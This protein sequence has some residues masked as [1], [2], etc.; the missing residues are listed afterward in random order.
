MEIKVKKLNERAILPTYGSEDAACADLYAIIDTPTKSVEI[1][2]H[3]TYF[4]STG[5]SMEIPKGYVG[6]IYPRS[7]LSCKRGLSLANCVGVIDSDYR[8]EI[9]VALVN[10][11]NEICKIEDAERCSQIAFQPSMKWDF[12]QVDELS[13]TE[14]GEGGFGSTG[15]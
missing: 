10:H 3:E 8:G 12:H 1:K 13:D 11:S 4:V 14:R 2:P 6:L 15:K 7:G 9:K 5:I